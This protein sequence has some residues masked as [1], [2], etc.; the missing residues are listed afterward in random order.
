MNNSK[1]WLV[2]NPSVGVPIFLTAVAVGSFSV[3]VAVLQ[4]TSWVD[5]FLSG[6]EMG[7]SMEEAMLP[8]DGD[9]TVSTASFVAQTDGTGILVTM[10][11]GTVAHAV[12]TPE[13]S[14]ALLPTQ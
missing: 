12:L 8:I 3:H 13:Q 14:A 7:S 6:E 2:V 1:I 10:P 4:N 9:A 5:D 11:D